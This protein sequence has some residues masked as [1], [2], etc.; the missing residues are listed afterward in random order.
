MASALVLCA[1]LVASAGVYG[2]DERKLAYVTVVFRHGDRSSIQVFENV[3]HPESDWPQGFGQL[4]QKGMR[5]LF[6][7]GQFLRNR[8]KGF[9]SEAYDR[10]EIYVRSTDTDRTLM[11]A[12]A[13]LA[14]L[15]PP[16]GEQMFRPDLKWQ[17]I[18][19]HTVSKKEEKLLSFPL[20]D[21]PRY[22]QLM[23]ETKASK[24]FLDVDKAYADFY[25]LIRK[26]TGLSMSVATVWR[27]Y[28]ILLCETRHDLAVPDWVTPEVMDKLKYLTDF[29]LQ[30]L[31]VVH[32]HKE[33]SRLQGGLL[34]GELVK[35]LNKMA[36]AGS[37]EKLKMMLLSGHDTT[38]IALQAALDVFSGKQPPY[39]SCFIV[40][41]YK[42][43][44]GSA[45]VSM[46]YRND[47]TA[48]PYPLQLPGCSLNCPLN[49]FVRITKPH[50]SDDREKDCQLPV[51]KIEKTD[52]G[53]ECQCG[54]PAA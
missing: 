46:F 39:S 41:L 53:S 12:A 10:R 9:L 47:T 2:L 11:S 23:N 1:L 43:A 26:N 32:Q 52:K 14:G 15:Y 31:F 45:S 42:E 19:I 54:G 18:P 34:L 16:S 40:E 7:L 30:A 13:S 51:E 24:E 8:Y 6:E 22:K 50:V 28:D 4:T 49:E 25:E 38:I 33:K 44:D 3:T 5:Q 37:D 48:D 35:N 17:P 27:L 36:A 20:Y 29:G 21:C